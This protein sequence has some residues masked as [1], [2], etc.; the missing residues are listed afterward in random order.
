M[1]RAAAP[2]SAVLLSACSG[3][4]SALDPA[5]VEAERILELFLPMF[6]GAVVVWVLVIGLAYYATRSRRHSDGTGGGC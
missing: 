6:A 3:P 5:G 2:V 4:Q 1:R